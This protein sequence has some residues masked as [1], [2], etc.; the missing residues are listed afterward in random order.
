MW[1]HLYKKNSGFLMQTMCP[2][3]CLNEI[4]FISLARS[5]EKDIQWGSS[6]LELVEK[7]HGRLHLREVIIRSGSKNCSVLG[8][9]E[10]KILK[11]ET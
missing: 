11:L 7:R 4:P 8:N 5:R 2:T 9:D 3:K 10:V 1:L 6:Y